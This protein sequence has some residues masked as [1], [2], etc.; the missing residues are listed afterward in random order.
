M[1]INILTLFPEF[2]TGP[3]SC[4]IIKRAVQTEKLKIDFKNFRDFSTNN[5]KSVDDTPYGGGAGMVLR[6]DVVHK[7][8]DSLDDKGTVIA[9]TPSGKVLDDKL[10]DDLALCKNLTIVCGHYEGFDERVYNYVD[11]EISIGDYVLSGGESACVVLVDAISRKLDGVINKQS[12]ENDSFV[13]GILDYPTYT[14]PLEYNGQKVPEVLL[15]GNHQ[16][17]A[18]YRY[19][20]AIKKTYKNRKDLIDKNNDLIDEKILKKVIQ[21]DI[22]GK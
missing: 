3:F 12:V 13:N 16:K 2:F 11:Q 6:V 5:Y 19:H 8:L 9:L 10:V 15:S 4:S 22:D 1:K 17:I 7:C 18:R 21:E 20:Q 14:K